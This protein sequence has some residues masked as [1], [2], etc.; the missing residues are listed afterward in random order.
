MI[1]SDQVRQRPSFGDSKYCPQQSMPDLLPCDVVYIHPQR[2]YYT[3]EF[4]FPQGRKFRESYCFPGR[5][6]A[7]EPIVKDVQRNES[8]QHH[9]PKRRR[10]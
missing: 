3:V 5:G 4:T 9:K 6:N 2:R 8:N 10:R 1:V 7:W